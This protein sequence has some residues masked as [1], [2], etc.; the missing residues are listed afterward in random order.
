MKKTKLIIPAIGMLL[1]STA[2][3]ITGTVAWFSMNTTVTATGMQVT[4]QSNNLFLQIIN[5]TGEFSDTES[6]NSAIAT[7]A[8]KDVFPVTVG[9]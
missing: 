8:S 3:S 1:L 7:T 4:A 2:A 5:S 9:S 6:Q